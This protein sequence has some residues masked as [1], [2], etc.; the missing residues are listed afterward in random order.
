LGCAALDGCTTRSPPSPRLG[1]PPVMREITAQP[2]SQ[3]AVHLDL[4]DLCAEFEDMYI[5][6]S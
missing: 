1:M 2:K 5:F 6:T 3:L 4:T